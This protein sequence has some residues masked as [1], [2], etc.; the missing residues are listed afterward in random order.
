MLGHCQSDTVVNV[1]THVTKCRHISITA[2][3]KSQVLTTADMWHQGELGSWG[4]SR[5]LLD[6]LG[7][8]EG[9]LVPGKIGLNA[10]RPFW[11]E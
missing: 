5:C 7:D 1:M 3:K 11:A 2:D 9:V 6:F 4:V 8:G 10:F